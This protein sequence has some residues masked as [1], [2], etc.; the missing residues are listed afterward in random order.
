MSLPQFVIASF[1]TAFNQYIT[2]DPEAMP[3]F[4]DMEGRVIAIEIIGLNE[5]LYL[6]PASDGIMVMSDF[7]GEADTTLSG[8][9]LALARLSMEKNAMPV[10]FSGEVRI[11]GD[12]RLGHQFKKYLRV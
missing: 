5:T 12:T 9:P 7:D 1:E 10:L 11:S 4:E 8:T 3:R 6:F 2:L